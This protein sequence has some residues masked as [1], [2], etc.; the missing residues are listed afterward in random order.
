MTNVQCYIL[1]IFAFPTILM[2]ADAYIAKKNK[3][4]LKGVSGF[5]RATIALTVILILG[6]AIFH[7]LTR[8][9]DPDSKEIVS[10]II[11]MLAGL[12]S[13]IVGFYFGGRFAEKDTKKGEE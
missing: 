7:L 12:V 13:A 10:N 8:P 6:I 9:V 3:D 2:L 11:S 4:E 5:R 1:A